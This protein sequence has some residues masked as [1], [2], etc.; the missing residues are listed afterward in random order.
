MRVLGILTV[1]LVLSIPLAYAD[2]LA[3]FCTAPTPACT[4]N[5]DGTLVP[6]ASPTFGFSYLG[7]TTKL[8]SRNGTDELAFLLPSNEDLDPTAISFDVHSTDAG[9]NDA[10]TVT[11]STTLFSTKTW[12]YGYLGAYLGND[13]LPSQLISAYLNSE[14]KTLD[15]GITGYYVYVVDLGSTKITGTGPTFSLD[16]F[17]G[18]T[19]LPKGTYIVDFLQVFNAAGH[20]DGSVAITDP[21]AGLLTETAKIAEPGAIFLFGT[22]LLA[23]VVLARKQLTLRNTR[24]SE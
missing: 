13:G 20:N 24:S 14:V 4:A 6:S 21:G 1:I 11:D 7:T 3:G 8:K 22:A 23:L 5:V 2:S 12:H 18:L 9:T 10:T 17:T 16:D 19:G 15:P